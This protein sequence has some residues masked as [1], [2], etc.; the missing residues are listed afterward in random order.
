MRTNDWPE[1]DP[2]G[3]YGSCNPS[4]YRDPD[5]PQRR[6]TERVK[7]RIAGRKVTPAQRLLSWM[8]QIGRLV[9]AILFVG[10]M[11]LM[12]ML[13]FSKIPVTPSCATGPKSLSA[14][15]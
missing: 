13:I 9:L 3:E 11:W 5:A 8:L 12:W 4:N 6:Q 2:D 1:F 14:K 10:L 7:L 15:K